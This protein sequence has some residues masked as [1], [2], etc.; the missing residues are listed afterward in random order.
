MDDSTRAR[1]DTARRRFSP[2]T[3]YLN[4]ATHGLTPDTALAATLRLTHDVAG[5]LFSPADADPGIERARAAYARLLGVPAER[6]AI[7][8]HT[9]QFVGTIAASLPPGAEVLTA[10]REFSSVVHPFLARE[11]VTV[12]EVPLEHLAE[13]VG[14]DTRLVAVSAVQSSDGRIAPLEDLLAARTAHGARLMVDVTQAA[15]WLTPDADRIDY[16]VCSTYKWLLGSR[17]S[18]FLTGTDEALAE[19]SPLAANWYAAEDPWRNLYGGPLPLAAGARRLDLPPIWPAWAGLEHSLALLEEVGE[20]AVREHDVALGDLLRT[21]L[22]LEPTGSAIVSVPLPAGGMERVT[23]EGI[24]VAARDGRLRAAFHLYNTE[25]D[26]DRLVK[27]L[28][29]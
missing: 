12:R 15:G 29:S 17:G 11:D 2:E 25:E 27:V 16:T 23:A 7:G 24:V 20:A 4:T 13:E 21:S 3:V 19:L 1:L 28:T 26:V 18:A 9:S 6:T 14:P 5:G 8:S 22:D 10:E